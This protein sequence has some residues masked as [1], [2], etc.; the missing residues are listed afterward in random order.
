MDVSKKVENAL[1]IS[2]PEKFSQIIDDPN[3]RKLHDRFSSYIDVDAESLIESN[4]GYLI[5]PNSISDLE[6][7]TLW[8]K[9]KRFLLYGSK[10]RI[11]KDREK[12]FKE[13]IEPKHFEIGGDGGE[14][15]YFI[16]LND[17]DCTVYRLDLETQKISKKP[18]GL[19]KYMEYLSSLSHENT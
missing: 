17:P 2:L 16:K 15:I 12:W 3:S 9:V 8:G 5:N 11:L 1:K 10:R 4:K 6:N 14:G 13:W 19:S 7:G 18:Y